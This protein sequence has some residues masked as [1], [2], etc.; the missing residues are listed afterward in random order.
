M[1]NDITLE[2][3]IKEVNV[4]CVRPMKRTSHGLASVSDE[5]LLLYG[6]QTCDNFGSYVALRDL[7]MFDI[8]ELQWT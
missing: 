4:A 7:W 1:I 8:K 6:G 5:L 3:T 2:A